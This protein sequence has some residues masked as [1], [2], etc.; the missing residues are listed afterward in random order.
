MLRPR[1]PPN[2]KTQI[3]QYLAEQKSNSDFGLIWICTEEFEFLDLVDFRCVAFSVK[4][5]ILTHLSFLC[6]NKSKKKSKKITHT[7]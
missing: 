6:E 5:V 7:R 2:A 3:P 4:I 1:N